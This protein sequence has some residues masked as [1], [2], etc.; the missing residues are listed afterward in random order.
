MK[1]LKITVS[2]S[3]K[4]SKDWQSV[5]ATA[6][7]EVEIEQGEKVGEVYVQTAKFLRDLVNREAATAIDALTYKPAPPAPSVAAAWAQSQHPQQQFN[8]APAQQPVQQQYNNRP[9]PMQN[10][11]PATMGGRPVNQNGFHG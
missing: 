5:D 9:A 11:P 8:Q 2:C 7:V 4:R 6:S 3:T 10:P 1:A